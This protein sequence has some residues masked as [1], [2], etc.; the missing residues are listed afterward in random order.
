MYLINE[1]QAFSFSRKKRN[2]FTTDLHKHPT[3]ELFYVTSGILDCEVYA[4]ISTD[5]KEI[6]TLSSGQF[7]IFLPQSTHCQNIQNQCEYMMC[8]F[9][10]VNAK[11]DVVQ[12]LKSERFMSRIP[13]FTELLSGNDSYLVFNDT[14]NVADIFSQLIFHLD[15]ENNRKN[16]SFYPV[17]YELLI[18]ELFLRI[19]KCS[20]VTLN[21]N[22]G[23]RHLSKA[24]TYINENYMKN[25]SINDISDYTGV[26]PGYLQKLFRT[27]HGNSVFYFVTKNRMTQA[28]RLL[29]TTS[30]PIIQIALRTGYKS[31]RA[32]QAAFANSFGIS[33]SVFR[34][35]NRKY[36]HTTKEKNATVYETQRA[37]FG[38]VQ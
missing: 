9:G 36:F 1:F 31:L 4:D 38:D 24:V 22:Y 8:E 21:L 15:N 16:D 2:N 14:F 3:M 25:I 6:I 23:N 28:E 34:A 11:L 29:K 10:C 18:Y 27:V 7:I 26:S 5:E 19:N 32:F 20:Q 33:P 37:L 12:Y 13:N 35:Q 30:I 17:D